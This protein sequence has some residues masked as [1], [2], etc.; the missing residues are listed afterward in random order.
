MEVLR[1]YQFRA[2]RSAQSG[3]LFER[4]LASVG[5][6]AATRARML[7]EDMHQGASAIDRAIKKYPGLKRYALPNVISN[8]I[9]R[10]M[11]SNVAH[12]HG[13]EPCEYVAP[14]TLLALTRGFPR[15]YPFSNAEIFFTSGLPWQPVADVEPGLP[16]PEYCHLF[17]EA[18]PHVS[19]CAGYTPSGYRALVHAAVALGDAATFD[20]TLPSMPVAATECLAPFGKS[21]THLMLRRTPDEEAELSQTSAH[22]H[23]LHDIW[24]DRSK[25][26][27]GTLVLPHVLPAEGSGTQ[28]S[29]MT[30]PHKHAL[31][32]VF[33]PRG[34]RYSP[35]DSGSGCFA[36]NKPTANGNRIELSYDV[37][38]QWRHYSGGMSVTGLRGRCYAPLPA[39]PEQP[40]QSYDVGSDDM[41]RQLV[42][43]VAVLVDHLEQVFVPEVDALL[44][45]TPAWYEW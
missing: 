44:G 9:S 38:S 3:E 33:K 14:D 28:Y 31:V 15:T 37:G 34:Y 26:E 10:R 25:R 18:L 2:V 17:G 1:R 39:H 43:N 19:F 41:W 20:A 40:Y 4:V 7:L 5:P 30:L 29:P 16:G 12:H 23:E 13:G 32:N 21:R 27:M 36:L 45:R 35:V 11:L 22:L 24:R 8:G 42:E 6:R